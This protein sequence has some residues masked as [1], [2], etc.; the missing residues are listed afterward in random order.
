MRRLSSTGP[1]GEAESSRQR[2]RERGGVA[3]LFAILLASGVVMGMLALS[4]DV[5]SIMLERRQLQNGA[6]ATSLA[7]AQACAE[8]S[9]DCADSGPEKASLEALAGLNAGRDGLAQLQSRSDAANGM[10]GREVPTLPECSSATTNAS[11]TDL[12][13]CPPLPSWLTSGSGASVPYVETYTLTRSTEPDDTVLPRYFSQ[14]LTGGGADTSV[15]AC[16]RAAWGPAGSTGATLPLVI[17]YCEWAKKTEVDG[18]PGRKYAPGPPYSPAPG[19]SSTPLPAEIA[20]GGYATGIFAHDSGDHKCDTGPGKYYPGGFGWIDP[21]GPCTVT[22]ADAGNVPGSTGASAPGSCKDNNAIAKYVGTEVY[23]PIADSA[24]GTGSGG[25]FG[26]SGIASFYLAGYEQVPAAKPQS[27]AAFKQPAGVCTGKCN[28]SV[29]YIWG[30]FTSGLMPADTP[31]GTGP[32][33]GANV[34]TPAG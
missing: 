31:I 4:V 7:L 16:A 23:I 3:T 21:T 26:L 28:G 1:R 11:I 10:C 17:G 19:D 12:A 29:S 33:R 27:Y 13:E 14:M 18:V 20:A 34:V 24:S 6:D 2:R 30:W 5:G 22:F 9:A 15:S 25:S 32:S 8:N